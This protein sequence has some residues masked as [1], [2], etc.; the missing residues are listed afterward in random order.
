L[1]VPLLRGAVSY[2]LVG[3]AQVLS[4]GTGL[5][6]VNM[7]TIEEFALFTVCTSLMLLHVAQADLGTLAAVGYFFREHSGWSSFSKEILPAI[8][9]L[10]LKLFL[11]AGIILLT[12]FIV[13]DAARG[14]S[15]ARTSMLLCL[16]FGAAWFTM[17]SSLQTMTLRVRGDVN[18][19][20]GI[21]AAGSFVRFT[22]A[23]GLV[24]LGLMS[25]GAALV[26]SLLSA[27]FAVLIG[28]LYVRELPLAWPPPYNKSEEC[29]VIRYMLPLIPGSFYYALQPS[30][31][32]WLSAIYGNTQQIAEVGA[33]GRIGQI[34]AAVGIGLNLFVLPHLASLRDQAAFKR[35]YVRIWFILWGV[36]AAIFLVIAVSSGAIL[37]LLGPNYRGLDFEVML[38]AGASLLSVAAN[39]AVI[40]NR[41]N[42]WNKVEPLSTLALFVGQ[43][44]L[45]ALLPFDSTAGILLFG[46]AY[47]FLCVLIMFGIN[48]IGFL[49]PAWAAIS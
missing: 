44:I 33:I 2:G 39:Y 34:I 36:A 37:L 32:I 23:V 40:V 28:H 4:A 12:F 11:F 46:V 47:A 13:S 35:S 17:M 24:G 43:A 42:G 38:V 15:F 1:S 25:A 18:T 31:L 3:L 6:F 30:I 26:T 7:L 48:I 29:K 9:R 20:V 16:T 41:L 27:I 14:V 21:E 22:L 10:R 8:A 19:S 45:I 5:M 49:R